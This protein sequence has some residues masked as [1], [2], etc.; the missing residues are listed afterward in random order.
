M[1]FGTGLY[2]NLVDIILS[3]KYIVPILLS[4]LLSCVACSDDENEELNYEKFESLL[5]ESMTY[6]QI[7]MLFG[8]PDGDIGSGI[9]IYVY[10]L[11]DGTKMYI[12][13]TDRIHYARNLSADGQ[14]LHELI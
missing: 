6:Q 7:V 12:G 10:N 3:M 5:K 13:Y 2:Y 8:S 9:H 1:G 4:V 14:L 11:A